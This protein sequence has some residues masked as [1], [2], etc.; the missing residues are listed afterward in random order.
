MKLLLGFKRD[1]RLFVIGQFDGNR[2]IR[3]HDQ[4]ND[5]RLHQE[6]TTIKTVQYFINEE[7]NRYFE[8]SKH[9]VFSVSDFRN[10][11][12]DKS[13]LKFKMK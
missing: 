4:W 12:F 7:G 10:S 8:I 13:K 1:S 11:N 3:P 9:S 5:E 6:S 2:F